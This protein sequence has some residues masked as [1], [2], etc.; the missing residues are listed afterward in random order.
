MVTGTDI[1]REQINIAGGGALSYSQS[2]IKVKG[3]SIEC[4]INAEDP[5][6]GFRPAPGLITRWEIPQ[7]PGIRVDTA[8]QT[9]YRVPIYYDSLIAKVIAHGD[10]REHARMRMICALREFI[11][12]GI[13]TT[14]PF[15]IKV[16]E[17]REF[18]SGDVST[19]ILDSVADG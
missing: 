19:R 16:L 12:E 13:P 17:T 2:E 8:C 15:L 5:F 1:V 10:D 7:G 3:H 6:D 9:G 4:R 18:S 14:T 11:V